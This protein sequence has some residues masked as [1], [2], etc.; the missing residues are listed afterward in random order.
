MSGLTFAKLL[1][2]E[3]PSGSASPVQFTSSSA[4]QS[5]CA[6]R[7]AL[8]LRWAEV[9]PWIDADRKSPERDG[10]CWRWVFRRLRAYPRKLDGGC[11]RGRVSLI[12]FCRFHKFIPDWRLR[13]FRLEYELYRAV[14]R[15]DR[16]RPWPNSWW[17]HETRLRLFAPCSD[18]GALGQF[19]DRRG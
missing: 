8:G 15:R 10:G 2:A 5:P 12:L 9:A 6:I 14:G 13:R 11:W 1:R 18:A 17:A 7:D 16:R 3:P 4:W 19:R